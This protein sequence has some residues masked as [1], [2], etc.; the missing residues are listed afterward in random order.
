MVATDTT[1]ESSQQIGENQI[2]KET[3]RI[4][5]LEQ[6]ALSHPST[7]TKCLRPRLNQHI[8]QDLEVSNKH[9]L[10]CSLRW[11]GGKMIQWCVVNL[12]LLL[13]V[14][15][16]RRTPKATSIYPALP[17]PYLRDVTWLKISHPSDPSCLL[18]RFLRLDQLVILLCLHTSPRVM[19]DTSNV[20]LFGH[21]IWFDWNNSS[22]LLTGI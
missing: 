14:S 21:R 7:L 13:L 16:K 9:R 8:N 6:F 1:P 17:F 12:Y 4:N 15:N 19:H 3:T 10:P 5:E 20:S 11:R 18:A 2:C 22:P